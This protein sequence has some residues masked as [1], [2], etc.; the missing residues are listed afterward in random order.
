MVSLTTLECGCAAIANYEEN[1]ECIL[2]AAELRH[3]MQDHTCAAVGI[4]KG[5][6]VFI[7]DVV[8]PR[9]MMQDHTCAAKEIFKES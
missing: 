2:D 1:L 7:P 3:M 5:K 8:E 4:S 6:Q 9:L